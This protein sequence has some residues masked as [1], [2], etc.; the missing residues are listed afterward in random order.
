MEA[1]FHHPNILQ[2]KDKTPNQVNENSVDFTTVRFQ[3]K[4]VSSNYLI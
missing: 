2:I 3:L 1:P 4:V